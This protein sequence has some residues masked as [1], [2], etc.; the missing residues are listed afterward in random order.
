MDGAPSKRLL[1][2]Q[3]FWH[4]PYSEPDAGAGAVHTI[5]VT[6]GESKGPWDYY[7]VLDEVPADQA[8]RPLMDGGCPLVK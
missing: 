3:P 2:R 5:T 1:Q 7:K 8:F 6:L 4:S